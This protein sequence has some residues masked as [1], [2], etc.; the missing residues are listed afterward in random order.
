M[1]AALITGAAG[2]IGQALV[3]EF[4]R[5][6]FHVVATDLDPATGIVPCDLRRLATEERYRRAALVRFRKALKGHDLQVLV[7]NAATQRLGA[8]VDISLD[9]WD[10]TLAVNVTAP[11]LLAQAFADDLARH[12]GSI[13]NVTSIHDRLTKPRFVAY[14]T[15]KAALAGLTRALAVDLGGKVRVNAVSPAAVDTPMLRAGLHKGQKATLRNAHPAGRIAT[16][17]DV[18]KVALQLVTD[19]P[20]LT[21]TIIGLDGAIGSRLHE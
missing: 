1:K 4:R 2:A 12:S 8:M 10:A 21:G 20:F 18:A 6:G 5:A 9:D 17:S 3:A 16:P 15:S 14:A 19:I 7:N 11:F 13:I